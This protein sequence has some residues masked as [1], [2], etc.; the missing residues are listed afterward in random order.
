MWSPYS[1]KPKI[2]KSWIDL[3]EV[4]E[5]LSLEWKINFSEIVLELP[6]LFKVWKYLRQ[7][8]AHRWIGIDEQISWPACSPDLTP[9]DFFLWDFISDKVYHKHLETQM[10]MGT[11][12]FKPLL[13]EM[14]VNWKIFH[15]PKISFK[16]RR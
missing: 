1:R 5:I 10:S 13:Q 16:L 8:L 12:E 15:K 3:R 14:N 2:S 7:T 6:I 11:T 9:R 4:Q